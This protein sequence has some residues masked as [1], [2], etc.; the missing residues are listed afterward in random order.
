MSKSSPTKGP[1]TE[2]P[3]V[4]STNCKKT[5]NAA[6]QRSRRSKGVQGTSKNMKRGKSIEYFQMK[7]DK[8]DGDEDSAFAQDIVARSYDPQSLYFRIYGRGEDIEKALYYYH[9]AADG[10]DVDAQH[11]V[12]NFYAGFGWNC[13]PK[14][15]E[16]AREMSKRAERRREL[17]TRASNL[18][19]M[20][21]V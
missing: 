5:T 21:G 11:R 14:Q 10:G 19:Q 3:E 8:C 6:V 13:L 12:G 9:K 18:L 17:S 4:S 20:V 16:R 2:T 1:V 15:N 7:A